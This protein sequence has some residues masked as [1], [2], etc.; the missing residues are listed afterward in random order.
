[1]KLVVSSALETVEVPFE[2]CIVEMK[3]DRIGYVNF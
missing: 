3:I 2:S 1:M